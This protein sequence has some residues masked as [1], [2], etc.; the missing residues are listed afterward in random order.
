M[1]RKNIDCRLRKSRP[2]ISGFT[3]PEEEEFQAPY[4]K[5]T[6]SANWNQ[7]I[8]RYCFSWFCNLFLVKIVGWYS[9]CFVGMTAKIYWQYLQQKDRYLIKNSI[10]DEDVLTLLKTRSFLAS[11]I[12]HN[13]STSNSRTLNRLH[14]QSRLKE[15][16]LVG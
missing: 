6:K 10:E 7:Y 1:E 5:L 3:W 14:N 2:P 15:L 9:K 12:D 4:T 13:V 16:G 11:Q 8:I